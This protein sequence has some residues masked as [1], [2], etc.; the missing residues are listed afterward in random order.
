VE[1]DYSDIPHLSVHSLGTQCGRRSEL[2]TQSSLVRNSEAAVM[3]VDWLV[4]I[5]SVGQQKRVS[6]AIYQ[7][8]VAYSWN[9]M[10]CSK[11]GM[12]SSIVRCLQQ[13]ASSSLD[14]PVIGKWR[15]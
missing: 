2:S 13:S 14:V 4:D 15:W 8:C 9:A 10:Q 6:E 1:V 7:L 5:S 12:L 3:L 11:A